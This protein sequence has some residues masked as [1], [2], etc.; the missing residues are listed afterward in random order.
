MSDN[1]AAVAE[2]RDIGEKRISL[3]KSDIRKSYWLWQFFSHANYNYE[4]LQGTSFA[5]CMAPIIKKLYPAKQDLIEGLK[6]HLAFF[7][8][9]PNFGAVIHGVTIA[10]EEERANGADISGDS[11]NAVKVGLMGPMAG[12]GDTLVQGIIIPLMVAIGISF[13]VQGNVFGPLFVLIGLPIVLIAIAYN[14]WMRGYKLGSNAVTTLLSGGRM[15]RTIGAASILGC[16]VMGGLIPQFVNFKTTIVFNVGKESFD[17]QAK[18]FDAI[19]PNLLPLL[20]TIVVYLLLKNGKLKS[21]QILL[22]LIVIGF[23]G[24]LLGIL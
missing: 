11:I 16:T 2:K 3:T 7:N 9:E 17:L 15:K 21:L 23:F 1:V 6:R 20:A 5:M 4:R 22:G 8:T 14:S 24:G 10:M 12:I 18:L 19:M 13:G